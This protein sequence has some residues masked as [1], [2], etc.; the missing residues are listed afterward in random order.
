[1]SITAGAWKRFCAVAQPPRLAGSLVLTAGLLLFGHAAAQE[2]AERV[3]VELRSGDR[4]NGAL[5]DLEG[6]TLFVRVSLHEQRKIPMATSRSSIASAARV[7]CRKPSFARPAP[8]R[9]SWSSPTAGAS[10]GR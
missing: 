3:T 9:R 8:P 7:A 1:M 5:E 10:T 6:G 2:P 4:V